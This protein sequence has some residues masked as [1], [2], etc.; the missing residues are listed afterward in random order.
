MAGD[1]AGAAPHVEDGGGRGKGG[2]IDR[3]VEEGAAEED[4]GEEVVLGV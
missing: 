2:R 3:R 1:Y 4:D